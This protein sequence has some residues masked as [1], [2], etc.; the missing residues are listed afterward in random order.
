[1]NIRLAS[2][3]GWGVICPVVLGG[4][5]VGCGKGPSKSQAFDAIQAGP[6][7]D[8]TCTLPVDILSHVKMQY[9]T[10]GICVP[11][12]GSDKARACINALVA[13]G[14][15]R[16]MPPDYMVGWPDEVSS[17]S[18]SDIPAYERRA[19]NLVYSSCVELSGN[20]RDGRFNCA[21]VHASKVLKVT[22]TDETHADVLYEREI[23]MRPMITAVDTACGVV[24]RP[25]GES[26]A[27]VVKS[28]TGWVLA[29]GASTGDGG[30][31]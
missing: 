17:A 3:A 11:R 27:S 28:G 26:T 10:K 14:V 23:A 15:T 2:R 20:L 25:P 31:N 7:E 13:A 24:T 19:R 9:A 8:G 5:L 22:A 12:E 21:D 29:S 1:M 6:R 16:A 18:L 30:A 4:L